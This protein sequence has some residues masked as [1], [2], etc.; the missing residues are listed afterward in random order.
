M[1]IIY[2]FLDCRTISEVHEKRAYLIEI[3]DKT[4]KHGIFCDELILELIKIEKTLYGDKDEDFIPEDILGIEI[5]IS[6]HLL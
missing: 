6:S 5:F 1:K 4:P 3:H 2:N